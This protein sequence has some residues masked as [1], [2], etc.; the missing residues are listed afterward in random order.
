MNLLGIGIIFSG[1][2]GIGRYEDALKQGWQQPVEYDIPRIQKRLPVYAVNNG[3]IADKVLLKKMRRADKL[4]KMAVLAASD[5]IKDS[6]VDINKNRTGIILSTAFGAHQT[7]FDFLDNI[8]DYG[9][10]QVSPTIFSNSVHNAAV[11]YITSALD[12]TGPA[13]TVTR[14]SFPFQSAL[15]LAQVWLLDGR[16]DSVLVG[17]A[18]ECGEV[19]RYI[20]DGKLGTATDG[21]VRPFHFS[22]TS[23]PVPGEGSVFFVVSWKSP[24]KAY[25]RID[26]IA[27]NEGLGPNE[28]SD[29]DLIDSDG[30]IDG[31]AYLKALSPTV[32]VAAYSPLFGSLMTGSAF[33]CAAGALMI[34][35]QMQYAGPILENPH[36]VNLVD[37][38]R[39]AGIDLIRSIGYNCSAESAVICL[40]KSRL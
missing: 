4:S 28:A 18:D 9:E 34:K 6:G 24:E 37:V 7:T 16:C 19:M 31:T 27:F 14:F 30:T 3:D 8:I 15:Q 12:I 1:G 23:P 25:C 32:P 2:R 26:D 29:I 33:N 11:S 40:R 39:P 36:N 38:S 22:P 13:L 35:K 20:F 17:V 5:A 21:K 10:A